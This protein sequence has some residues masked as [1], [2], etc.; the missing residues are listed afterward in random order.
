MLA[1]LR[2]AT[3]EQI[4]QRAYELYL[5]RGR[6]D[7][8]DVEDWLTAEQEMSLQ[9]TFADAVKKQAEGLLGPANARTVAASSV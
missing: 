1:L 4:E 5:G 3:R 7:G 9:L 6:E 8:K 2:T